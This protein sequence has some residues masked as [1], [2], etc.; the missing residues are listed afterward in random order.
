[1]IQ[2]NTIS[3]Y[4]QQFGSLLIV[5]VGLLAFPK[6]ELPL[7]II[8]FYGANSFFFQL[9]STVIIFTKSKGLNVN[10]NGNLY[11]L[12]EALILLGF[13]YSLFKSSAEKKIV[14]AMAVAYVILYFIFM[15][16]RW[17]ELVSSIRTMRDLVIIIC[18]IMYFF[19]LMREMPTSDITKYPMFW[20]VAAMLSFFAGT[21]T[22]SLSLNYLVKVLHNDLA[23]IWAM[24]NFYR[25]IFCFVVCYG[26]WLDRR[27]LK[28]NL[29]LT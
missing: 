12:T 13:F 26:L 7:K 17:N 19:Y 1:M 22:L 8:V 29:L 5:L 16:D 15:I 9:V 14:V 21:F 2:L 25:V 27:Q 20:I 3:T 11:T 24:R 4:S 23:L 18:G 10:V 6:R 28:I